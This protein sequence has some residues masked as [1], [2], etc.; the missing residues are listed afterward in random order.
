MSFEKAGETETKF[1]CD[2]CHKVITIQRTFA[3]ALIKMFDWG[4]ST[5]KLVSTPWEHYCPQCAPGAQ[6]RIDRVRTQN[7]ER[8]ALRALNA[9]SR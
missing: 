2:D 3:A 9:R 1:I 8:A 7:A 6:E 4:W 5:M